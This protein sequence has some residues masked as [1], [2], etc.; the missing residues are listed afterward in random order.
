VLPK[1]SG[2]HFG[3][4]I[5]PTYCVVWEWEWEWEMGIGILGLGFGMEEQFLSILLFL[6]RWAPISERDVS[7]R[8]A[9]SSTLNTILPHTLLNTFYC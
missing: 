6:V 8:E 2:I 9:Q 4:K 5:W 1:A 7:G 3:Y